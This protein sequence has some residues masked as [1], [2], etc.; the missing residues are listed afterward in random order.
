MSVPS[1]VLDESKVLS[2][3]VEVCPLSIASLGLTVFG[4]TP[5]A[6]RVLLLFVTARLLVLR[7]GEHEGVLFGEPPD[8]GISS[9]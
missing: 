1:S 5:P 2:K 4:E 6:V 8:D 9:G 7:L 3:D